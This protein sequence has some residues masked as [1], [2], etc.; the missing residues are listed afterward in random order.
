MS[1]SHNYLESFLSHK[2]TDSPH[3]Y[4]FIGIFSIYSGVIII[5]IVDLIILVLWAVL[6]YYFPNE[7]ELYISYF[8]LNC[9]R[10]YFWLKLG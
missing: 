5:G 2:T 4:T 9:I 1:K 3:L 7:G 10:I 6:I 8:I